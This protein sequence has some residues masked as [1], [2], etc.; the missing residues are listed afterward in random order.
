MFLE[1]FLNLILPG[2]VCLHARSFYT[3]S[4][5]FLSWCNKNSP[6][7][8]NPQYNHKH[9]CLLP[10]VFVA[11]QATKCWV[12]I[13]FLSASLFRFNAQVNKCFRSPTTML[14]TWHVRLLWYF[15]V[16][17]M[18]QQ[19]QDSLKVWKLFGCRKSIKCT[20]CVIERTIQN[21]MRVQ[22]TV[23]VI[24]PLSFLVLGKS[25]D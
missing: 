7:K 9:I 18:Q 21:H 16:K 10:V 1:N 20:L 3:S 11:I 22:F 6:Q 13:T 2:N 4:W 24:S 25:S 23:D 12:G 5:F 15:C 14:L 19:Q 17:V 8:W